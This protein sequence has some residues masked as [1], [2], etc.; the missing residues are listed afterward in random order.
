[1]DK[2]RTFFDICTQAFRGFTRARSL[3]CEQLLLSKWIIHRDA[4]D[5]DEFDLLNPDTAV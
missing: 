4:D 2:A 1:M 3:Q 5:F